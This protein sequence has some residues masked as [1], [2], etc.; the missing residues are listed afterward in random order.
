METPARLKYLVKAAIRLGDF[1]IL[2]GGPL[3]LAVLQYLNRSTMTRE[4]HIKLGAILAMTASFSVIPV[5][6]GQFWDYHYFP[7]IFFA[8][9][10]AVTCL[11]VARRTLSPFLRVA[12][13]IGALA[14][15]ALQGVLLYDPEIISKNN[16]DMKASIPA[17]TGQRWINSYPKTTGLWKQASITSSTCVSITNRFG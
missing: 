1:W 16:R 6:S 10:C 17:I 2:A 5:I 14:F 8:I 13:G 11:G 9:L 12:T 7:Y 15:P 4:H 3:L